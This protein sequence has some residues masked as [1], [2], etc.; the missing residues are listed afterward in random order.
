MMRRKKEDRSEMKRTVGAK[1]AV[2]HVNS[3]HQNNNQTDTL[4]INKK[5]KKMYEYQEG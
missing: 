1:A 4:K 3:E 5:K 2:T